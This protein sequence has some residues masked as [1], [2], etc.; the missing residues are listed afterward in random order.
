[1]RRWLLAAALALGAAPAAAGDML[2]PLFEDIERRTFDFFWE[3][4]VPA[5]AAT[6]RGIKPLPQSN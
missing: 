3:T 5:T 1:M 4:T 2:P 6:H